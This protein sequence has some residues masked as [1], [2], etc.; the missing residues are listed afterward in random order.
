MMR[1]RSRKDQTTFICRECGFT[2]QKWL[3]RCPSC[4]AW[5]TL[6]ERQDE[7]AGRMNRPGAGLRTVT[8]L[9]AV[10]MTATGRIQTGIGELDRILGGG[11]VRGSVALLG[12]PPGIGKS[13]IMTQLAQ[14]ASAALRVLYVSAE[15]SAEQ[16]KQRAVRLGADGGRILVASDTVVTDIVGWAVQNPVDLIILDPI[17]SV[18]H[19]HYP[20]SPGSPVQLRECA[21]ALI[22]LAKTKNIAVFILGHITKDGELAGPK[23]LEH[24]V[25]TVL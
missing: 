5:N 9:S 22:M 1:T 25:D 20:G 23:L 21:Q 19:P 14:R 24:L 11:M 2:A 13:T 10:P 3:G 6:Q 8:T 4:N 12:G 17:Q 15:E 7:P 16:L 18:A